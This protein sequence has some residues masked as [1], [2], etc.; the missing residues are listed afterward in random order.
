MGL[1]PIVGDSDVFFVLLEI[2]QRF[3]FCVSFT[4]LKVLATFVS[5]LPHGD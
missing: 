2:D 5:F 3:I 1:I 4:E